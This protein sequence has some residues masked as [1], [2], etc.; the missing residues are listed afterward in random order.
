MHDHQDIVR[1]VVIVFIALVHRLHDRRRA[2]ASPRCASKQCT[3]LTSDFQSCYETYAQ[4]V[5]TKRK[6]QFAI[7]HYSDLESGE[8]SDGIPLPFEINVGNGV[9]T[10]TMKD[11]I[12]ICYLGL[13]VLDLPELI[14]DEHRVRVSFRTW[15]DG[16]GQEIKHGQRV[17]AV[18][19]RRS[20]L[21]LRKLAF[22]VRKAN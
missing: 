10:N 16:E 19:L 9:V 3:V 20:D 17:S 18:E 8:V 4:V 2:G 15:L 1:T 22:E 21:D 14:S 11:L 7:L 5:Q 6:V 13:A 12:Y